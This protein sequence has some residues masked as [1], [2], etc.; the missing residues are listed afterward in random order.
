[1]RIGKYTPRVRPL[2]EFLS[3]IPTALRGMDIAQIQTLEDLR[4]SINAA[5]DREAQR[6]YHAGGDA[7]PSPK[8]TKRQWQGAHNFLVAVD[9]NIAVRKRRQGGTR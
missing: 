9:F 4:G 6:E 7:I 3:N 5:I 8:W 2:S 1:M